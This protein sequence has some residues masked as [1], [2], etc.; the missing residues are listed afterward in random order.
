MTLASHRP[1]QAC[2]LAGPGAG[3]CVPVPLGQEVQRCSE[4]DSLLIHVAAS[5]ETS[6][7]VWWKTSVAQTF[8]MSKCGLK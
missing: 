7:C 1:S 6:P 5:Q 8:S 3:A 2:S 4:N